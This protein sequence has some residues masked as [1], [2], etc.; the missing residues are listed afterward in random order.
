MVQRL[1][2]VTSQFLQ[3]LSHSGRPSAFAIC[4]GA[5]VFPTLSSD[6]T[7]MWFVGNSMVLKKV[8]R[9][10]LIR[11]HPCAHSGVRA[12]GA[13]H[14]SHEGSLSDACV[15][16]LGHHILHYTPKMPSVLEDTTPRVF[17]ARHG[18]YTPRT[19]CKCT[20]I[21]NVSWDRTGETEWTLNGRYT[22]L[23]DLP[24][25]SPAGESQVLAS[26][27]AFVGP[28][29]LIDPSKLARVLISPR[30]RAQQTAKLLLGEHTLEELKREGKV[31][32]REEIREWQ[33]GRYEGWLTKDIK[34]DR[35]GRG[36]DK[37]RE[38]DVWRD[39][40]EDGDEDGEMAKGE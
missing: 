14:R 10:V 21:V 9:R 7:S 26:S 28:H 4:I 6:V 12:S 3:C 32:T 5:R 8:F 23:T 16:L 13:E 25:T 15:P 34:R 29:R 11:Q 20:S 24:L 2:P 17:L 27:D 31:A 35:K 40:C 37:D 33:Y 36:L 19:K 22:G 38:W 18:N 39:G 30:H 1:Y